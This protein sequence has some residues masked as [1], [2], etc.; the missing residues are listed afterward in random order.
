M[1][2][3]E[4]LEQVTRFLKRMEK[5]KFIDKE[6]VKAEERL[7]KKTIRLEN[8]LR[9][10]KKIRPKTTAKIINYDKTLDKFEKLVSMRIEFLEK[11]FGKEDDLREKR[12]KESNQ[13]KIL[14]INE[15]IKKALLSQKDFIKLDLVPTFERLRKAIEKVKRK[16]IIERLIFL[17]LNFKINKCIDLI[18]GIKTRLEKEENILRKNFPELKYVS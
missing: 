9:G 5:S 7:I 15:K 12:S 16:N 18:Y 17:K 14:D 10:L 13:R 6:K 2:K 4:R 11:E 3:H 1:Q 8:C